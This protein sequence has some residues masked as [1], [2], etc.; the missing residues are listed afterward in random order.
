[1]LA[2][3]TAVLVLQSGAVPPAIDPS[4]I[5]KTQRSEMA[6]LANASS[7]IFGYWET[8]PAP[9]CDWV[10]VA[11]RSGADAAAWQNADMGSRTRLSWSSGRLTLRREDGPAMCGAGWE[12]DLLMRDGARAVKRCRVSA[13]RARM[14]TAK[15][16]PQPTERVLARGD[17]ID[18]LPLPTAEPE[19]FFAARTA[20]STQALG[21][22]RRADVSCPK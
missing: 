18:T 3:A 17:A 11:A 15:E 7:V 12:G 21:L 9:L 14:F 6:I 8:S 16:S 1:M 10:D 22:I 2:I 20:D 5:Y 13:A 19:G 4:G